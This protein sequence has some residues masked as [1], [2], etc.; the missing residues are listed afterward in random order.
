VR[1]EGLGQ[2]KNPRTSLGI[3]PATF[4]LVAATAVGDPPHI[5]TFV[6]S[7]YK[8]FFGHYP[9]HSVRKRH[10]VMQFMKPCVSNYPK[11]DGQLL[12]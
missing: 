6:Y 3:E 9:S 7:L 1:L 5:V 11:N 4:R 8:C 10:Q 12:T 2:L